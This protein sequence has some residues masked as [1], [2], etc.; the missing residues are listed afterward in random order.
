MKTQRE[1]KNVFS[2]SV[3]RHNAFAECRRMYYYRHYGFWGGWDPDADP[4]LREIYVLKNLGNRFTF[5]GQVVHSVVAEIIDGHRYGREVSLDEA[6]A[7]ALASLRTGFR[8]SRD[9]EN[10]ENPKH[11]VGLF[12]HE[13]DEPITDREWQRMRDRVY[14]CLENFFAS[15]IRE[16]VFNTRIENWLP[17][18]VMDSFEFEG[19]TVYV[20]PDFA[21]R[22]P[23]GNALVIDWKS[24][25]P[26][27]RDH[28]MQI[29][30]YGLYAREKWGIEPD[31]A[32]GELHYLLSGDV[33]IITLDAAA[34]EEGRRHI[35]ESIAAMKAL[36]TD[37]EANMAEMDRFPRIAERE[38]CSR[39]NFRRLCW[40]AW[41]EMEPGE[42]LPGNGDGASVSAGG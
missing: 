28:R 26:D 31:R 7:K 13:Y 35:R 23:Q 14:K 38:T 16:T 30:C 32:I 15:R 36:L 42:L 8:Q 11:H 3:S 39:C 27:S 18:D 20:A 9:H 19:V 10:R 24:G 41:P 4:R 1:L 22:N 5:A 37:A 21:I 6:K 33:S 40:P 12:E 25:W 2:W 29:V 34:L 17:V